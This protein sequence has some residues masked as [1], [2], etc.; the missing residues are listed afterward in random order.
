MI[1]PAR[2]G[3]PLLAAIAA[4]AVSVSVAGCGGGSSTATPAASTKASPTPVTV[5]LGY[6]PNLTHATAIVGVEDGLF[7]KALKGNKLKTQTFNAGPE[8]TQALLSGAIDATY[9]GP[10]PST[11]AYAKSGG[12]AVRIVS[13]ATSGGAALVVKPS[14]TSPKDLK[15]KKIATPQ[16]GNTQDIALRYWLKQ[17]GFATTQEGGGDVKV[18]PQDNSQTVDTF[19]TG[20]IDGA[21]VPEPT[22][23][24]LVNEGGKVL[25]DERTLWPG[26]KFVTTNLLVS[27]SFLDKHPDVVKELIEGQVA[28]N[29]AVNADPAHAQAVVAAAIGKLTGKAL[30]ATLVAQAWQTLSFTN[31]PLPATLLTGAQH[32]T[33]VG[34]LKKVDKLSG[35]YDLRL[36]NEVLSAAGESPVAEP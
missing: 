20:A 21:W 17:Q 34:L 10:G 32:A 5:R 9:I 22:L 14:I 29:K 3:L 26:G 8:A 23:S 36:L 12:Q 2:P 35:I 25:V 1:R 27:K 18:F 7:A 13:G 4:L 33:A 24:R 11:N 28:A 30:K 6:F 15:G 19:G 16:L 31:D